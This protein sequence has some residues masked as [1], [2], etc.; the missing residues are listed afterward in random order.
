[1]CSFNG[2]RHHF[3][4]WESTVPTISSIGRSGLFQFIASFEPAIPLLGNDVAGQLNIRLSQNLDAR[5]RHRSL[6]RQCDK[7]RVAHERG[8]SYLSILRPPSSQRPLGIV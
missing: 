3:C 4:W 5:A 2:M 6:I 8:V 1:M 7:Q